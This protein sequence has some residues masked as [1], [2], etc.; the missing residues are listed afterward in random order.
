MKKNKNNSQK[1]IS[2]YITIII[3]GLISGIVF[4]LSSLFLNQV[5]MSRTIGDSF[6]AFY[7]A[8]AGIEQSLYSIRIEEGDGLITLTDLGNGQEYEVES[9]GDTCRKSI[10]YYSDTQRSIQI[11]Y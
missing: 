2:L 7:A 3:L 8:D 10:G 4:G 1:G 5:K 6:K 11:T 9:C